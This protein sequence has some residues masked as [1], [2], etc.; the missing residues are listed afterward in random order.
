MKKRVLKKG[1][2]NALEKINIA[3]I[4][5]LCCVQDFTLQ[6]F[7]VLMAMFMLLLINC[8]V[9]DKYKKPFN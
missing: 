5:I 6:G 8:Y 1:V 2:Q 4:I 7:F 9:L 3:I